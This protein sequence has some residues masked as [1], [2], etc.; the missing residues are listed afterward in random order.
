MANK[1]IWEIS[2]SSLA[3][4]LLLVSSFGDKM[5]STILLVLNIKA[6]KQQ[7]IVVN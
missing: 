7:L 1:E 2:V 5:L 3:D 6:R 4:P